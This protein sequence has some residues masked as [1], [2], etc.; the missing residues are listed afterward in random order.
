MLQAWFCLLRFDL[1][2]TWNVFLCYV[3]GGFFYPHE[4]LVYQALFIKNCPLPVRRLWDL[5]FKSSVHRV[6]GSGLELGFSF[7]Q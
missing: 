6:Y 7:L 5:C 4:Y 2:F 3:W 1:Q